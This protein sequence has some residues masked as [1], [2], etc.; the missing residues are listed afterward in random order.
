[1]NKENY[2]SKYADLSYYYYS[3]PLESSMQQTNS[4][5]ALVRQSL[6]G[7]MIFTK[8][9]FRTYLVYIQDR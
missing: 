1:M 3:T 6:T 9:L 4:H 7:L 2:F 5:Q 8:L